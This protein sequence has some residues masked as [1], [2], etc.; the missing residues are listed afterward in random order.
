M[1]EYRYGQWPS[2]FSVRDMATLYRLNDVQ[3]DAQGRFLVWEEGRGGQSVLVAQAEDGAPRDLFRDR[4][5]RPGVGYGG[6]AFAVGRE[7]VLFVA[8]GRL[9]RQPLAAGK[10]RPI[11]PAF[12]GLAAPTLTPDDAWA[13]FVHTYENTDVLAAVRTDGRD[14]PRPIARGADFYMQPAFAP[15]GRFLAW[16]E[17]DFPNMPW[18]GARLMLARWDAGRLSDLRHLAGDADTP[19]FQPAFSPDGRYLAYLAQD[20]EWDTLY[21]Y[22]LQSGAP[23]PL[24]GDRA[25]ML[26]AWVQGLRTFA[27]LDAGH[28]LAL[29][30]R[31]GVSH[32]WLLGLDGSAT[33]V[34]PAPY[35]WLRQPAASPDGQRVAFLA[36][37]PQIPER[38]VVWERATGRW[39]VRARS[40]PENLPAEYL[41]VP[42]EVTWEAEDGLT[43]HAL[44]Y[45]PVPAERRSAE[46]PP[47]IVSV[48][49]GPTSQRVVNFNAQAA[50]FASRGYAYVELNYRGSTGYGRRYMQALYGRWGEVDVEDA[51]T[52]ARV[53]AER[54]LADPQRLAI[55][56]GSA[57]GYTVLNV[58]AR[59]PGVYRVGVDLYGVSDLFALD[60]DTHKFE[61]HY[62]E[63]LVGPLP[64]AAE[65][66]RAWSPLFHADRIRDP[67]A[68]FQGE[69]DKVVPPDQSERIVAALRRNGVPHLYKRYPNEGHGF[70]QPD[71]LE[72]LYASLER[73]LLIHL[74]FA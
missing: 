18:D 60:L 56:G 10:P 38:V 42:E 73:F 69:E 17:W 31:N 28:L 33:E 67:V 45:A 68:V 66:Y 41:P 70:R 63:K 49:G 1:T 72:D 36:S 58:L 54:G 2:P 61:Q 46:P 26:P 71:T 12:G 29:E 65:K 20:G 5:L 62:T 47:A 27:W 39:V 64:Q 19:V 51:V 32:V 15:T 22:D 7:S 52:L 43:V 21:L 44:Y 3:W 53:L 16:V 23:R 9:F 59:H 6:G 8:E 11:S 74:I 37:A 40:A 34:D 24:F 35:T 30:N 25:L 50:Y 14:W 48:H 4:R 57:G 13:V 55:M